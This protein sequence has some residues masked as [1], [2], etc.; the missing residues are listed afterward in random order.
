MGSFFEGDVGRTELGL[1]CIWGDRGGGE[2][3]HKEEPGQRPGGGI[4]ELSR[5]GG[6]EAGRVSWGQIIRALNASTSLLHE[7]EEATKGFGAHRGGLGSRWLQGS[8]D[9]WSQLRAWWGLD[10]AAC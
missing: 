8:I 5:V 3:F 10:K 9:H 1:V 2:I 6:D 7:Q 4:G